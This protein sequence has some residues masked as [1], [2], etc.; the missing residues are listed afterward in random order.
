MKLETLSFQ[1]ILSHTPDVFEAVVVAGHRARQINSRRAA[2]R[3]DF[4]E[5]YP[6]EDYL[7]VDTVD[8]EEYVAEEKSSVLAME[9]FLE[10]RL[11]WRY[12][13]PESENAD[14]ES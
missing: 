8:E 2:E 1:E 6:E 14:E 12:V 4:T 9:D 3:V 11:E 5:E 10:N 7:P 13:D